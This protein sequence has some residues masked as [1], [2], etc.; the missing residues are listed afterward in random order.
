MQ[1]F[2]A[3]LFDLNGVLILNRTEY[4]STDLEDK[5]FKRMGLSLEDEKEKDSI[6]KELGWS[7]DKFWN[8][9]DKSWNSVN[10]NLILI[11]A[12]KKIKTKGLKTGIITNTSGRIARTRLD[13]FFGESLD[14]LFDTII[15]SSE[16]GLLKPN[17]KIFK[18]A[19]DRINVKPEKAIF[20]DDSSH[21]LSGAREIGMH[22][23]LYKDTKSTI[24]KLQN[25]DIIRE[26]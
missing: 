14:K 18:L 21:Y 8:F 6:K 17:K 16:V 20:I 1:K 22:T 15:I 23:I 3:I 26:N 11:K 5:I 10:P 24:K 9:I 7:E 13:T 12:I 2:D 19:L 4:Q 25:L